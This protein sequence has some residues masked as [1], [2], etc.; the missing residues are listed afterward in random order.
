MKIAVEELHKKTELPDMVVEKSQ[1]E[2]LLL[3]IQWTSNDR[4]PQIPSC[5]A[6]RDLQVQL[7]NNAGAGDY[8]SLYLTN[9]FF[10]LL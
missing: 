7:P 4:K 6:H 1:Q 8:L 9:A 2:D 10:Y 5:T 3:E